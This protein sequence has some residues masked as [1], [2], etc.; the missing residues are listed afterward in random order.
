MPANDKTTEAAELHPVT[1]TVIGG[2]TATGGPVPIETGTVATTPAPHQPNLLVTVIPPVVAI[3]IRF[4]NTFLTVLLGLI[5]GAMATNVIP[6]K[7]FLD[8]VLKCAGL[9]IAGAGIGLIKDLV[10][11]FA[12]LEGRYPLLTG[13]V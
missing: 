7:D 11:I 4:A 13:N 9:S 3:L 5:T 8:L 12:R 1:V 2:G 10:T 6:A